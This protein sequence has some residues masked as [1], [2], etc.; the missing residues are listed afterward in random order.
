MNTNLPLR[1]IADQLSVA[2]QLMPDAMAELARLG[3]KSVINNRPDHEHGPD[4]P[5]SA[6][7]EAAALAA[8]LQYRHLP[9]DGGWQSPEQ[10]A[11]FARLLAELPAPVLA[12]CR[13][14]A[15]STR[16]YQQAAAL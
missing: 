13:S 8:G 16:L 6:Q 9:V 2:P 5:T 10:I 7:V 11:E 15:R 3:F 12:F 14:G 4:Q 1:A